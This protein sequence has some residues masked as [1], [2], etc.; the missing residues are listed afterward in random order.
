MELNTY[1]TL[2]EFKENYESDYF[3]YYKR[4]YPDSIF[5]EYLNNQLLTYSRLSIER[6]KLNNQL[7][8]DSTEETSQQRELNKQ[9]ITFS[10]ELYRQYC[11]IAQF[12][13]DR[14]NIKEG[15]DDE[16]IEL[17]KKHTSA[18]AKLKKER[19]ILTNP[20]K[21]ALLHELGVFDL[22][23]MKNLSEDKQ[24]ELIGL[25]LGADKTEF[26]YKNRLNL[27]SR[28]PSYQIDKYGSYKYVDEM[29]NLLKEME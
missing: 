23:I 24:N 20:Q 7:K 22:P 1:G 26:V 8:R 13:E 14:I 18:S 6:A 29:K 9:I 5:L 16:Q 12:L 17:I 10:E 27:N 11:L 25:V 19:I 28:D 3:G 15:N 2:A 4:E 21:L